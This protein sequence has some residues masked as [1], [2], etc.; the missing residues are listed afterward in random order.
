MTP[1]SGSVA[2]LS[3]HELR[4]AVR[5]V[6]L[7]VLP[8]GVSAPGTAP[9]GHDTVELRTDADLDAFVRRV[10][11]LCEDPAQRAALRDGPR[12]F[13]L[14]AAQ[15]VLPPAEG[16]ALVLRIEQGAVTE[17]VVKKAAADGA[18]LVLGPRAVLTP[19]ARDMA[20]TQ[21]VEIKK[22]R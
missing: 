11:D 16:T 12:R 5:A 8:A 1:D 10:A 19:L 20:R 7:E 9:G 15:E 13:R 22:E 3:T 18:R 14:C 2:G 17:R 4:S 6:L 21:G